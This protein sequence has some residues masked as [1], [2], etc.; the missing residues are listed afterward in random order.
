MGRGIKLLFSSPL[1]LRGP[2]GSLVS[3]QL[4]VLVTRV[5]ISAGPLFYLVNIFKWYRKQWPQPSI[6]FYKPPPILYRCRGSQA[7]PTAQDLRSHKRRVRDGISCGVVLRGFESHPLHYLC[8]YES[9]NTICCIVASA[10]IS[11][12]FQQM[13][14]KIFPHPAIASL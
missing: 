6:N 4:G 2:W 8:Y 13:L 7:R 10:I 9:F 14:S 5:Q 1:I 11:F 3:F 12:N